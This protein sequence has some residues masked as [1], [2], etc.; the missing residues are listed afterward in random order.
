LGLF[1]LQGVDQF[2]CWEEARALSVMLDGLGAEGGGN[3]R[4]PC[5]GPP[6]QHHILSPIQ[7]F[8]SMELA[9]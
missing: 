9:N 6:D 4:F 3:M 7:E 2:D 5:A 8:A 1:L